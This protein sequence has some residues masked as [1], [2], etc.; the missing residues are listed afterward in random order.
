MGF[1]EQNF[2]RD[3]DLTS[4]RN[5]LTLVPYA[6]R[7]SRDR[8][9]VRLTVCELRTTLVLSG[10]VSVIGGKAPAQKMLQSCSRYYASFPLCQLVQHGKT[11]Q[12]EKT[13]SL[14]HLET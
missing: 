5:R 13:L 11:S 12:S 14:L 8:V 9:H 7:L 2:V 1:P 4:I 6:G 10:T 3:Q